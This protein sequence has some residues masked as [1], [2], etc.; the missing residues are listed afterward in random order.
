MSKEVETRMLSG[1]FVRSPLLR[2]PLIELFC[3]MFE[4]KPADRITIPQIKAFIEEL[5]NQH[6]D[7]CYDFL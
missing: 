3:K 1:D 6:I 7:F 2:E 4:T 5:V